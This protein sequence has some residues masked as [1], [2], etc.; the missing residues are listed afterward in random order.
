MQIELFLVLRSL[1][2][3]K[4]QA[5]RNRQNQVDD[6]TLFS[7]HLGAVDGHRHREAGANQDR[8]IGRSHPDV[9]RVASGNKGGVV[10]VAIDQVCH[11]HAAEEHEFGQQE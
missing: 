7:A 10:P 5:Q 6:Q 4:S 1:D 11:E 8:R 3:K 2:A 9:E